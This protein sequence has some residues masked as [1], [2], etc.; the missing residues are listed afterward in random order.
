VLSLLEIERHELPPPLSCTPE[1][2]GHP[3]KC[4]L[5][6]QPRAESYLLDYVTEPKK[7]RPHRTNLHTAN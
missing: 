3:T 7:V 2:C 4:A 6:Y 5:T 1:L